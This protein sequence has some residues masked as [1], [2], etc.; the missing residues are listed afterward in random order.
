MN[1]LEKICIEF[2]VVNSLEGYESLQIELLKKMIEID[3]AMI[4]IYKTSFELAVRQIRDQK[5]FYE[6]HL[7]R[8]SI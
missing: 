8:R 4:Q 5:E 3:K 7:S 6:N 1:E 2:D